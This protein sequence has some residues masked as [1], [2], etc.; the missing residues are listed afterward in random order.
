[1]DKTF[2]IIVDHKNST[3]RDDINSISC[4][5]DVDSDEAID[6]LINDVKGTLLMKL[7]NVQVI[8]DE[9]RVTFKVVHER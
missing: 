4:E 9:V 3:V 2:T 7:G 5:W 1:M 6:V 8:P